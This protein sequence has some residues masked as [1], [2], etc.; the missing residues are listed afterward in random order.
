[1]PCDIVPVKAFQS[2][3]LNSKINTFSDVADR[4]LRNLGMPLVRVEATSDMLFENIAQACEM[5]TKYAGFTREYLIFDTRLYEPARGIRLDTLFTQYEQL[6]RDDDVNSVF[7]REL[8]YINTSYVVINDIEVAEFEYIPELEPIFT[9][10]LKKGDI[11]DI[12]KQSDGSTV[13]V[14]KGKETVVE[15]K[16]DDF[17]ITIGQNNANLLESIKETTK[18]NLTVE[19]TSTGTTTQKYKYFDYDLMNYRKVVA[20]TDYRTTGQSL[21][22]LS[23]QLTQVGALMAQPNFNHSLGMYGFDL[24]SFHILRDWLETREKVLATKVQWKFDD[25]TQYLRLYPQ[26]TQR[27]IGLIECYVE[28]PIRDIVKEMWVQ[29]YALA[30]TKIQVAHVRGKINNLSLLG[31]GSINYQDLMNQGVKEKEELEKRLYDMSSSGLGDAM[32]PRLF[33]G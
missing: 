28:K 23:D 29:Q 5:F 10:G 9:L 1:M 2:T 20:V 31:G 6:I 30:L 22:F 19:G 3:N 21:N 16:Q 11:I 12:R 15:L 4:I 33:I 24:V 32:P 26:P 18:E 8:R 17:L 27:F 7:G 13:L 25:R 14:Y